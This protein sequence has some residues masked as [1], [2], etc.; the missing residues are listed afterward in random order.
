[1]PELSVLV[2]EDQPFQRLVAVSALK[3]AGVAHVYEASDGNE[4]LSVLKANGCVDI[5]ICDLRM[6]GMDGLTFLHHASQ[7]GL[8]RSVILSSDL[9]PV[10]RQAT[11]SMIQSLGLVFLGDLGK[12]FNLGRAKV[13]LQRYRRPQLTQSTHGEETAA[14][15]ASDIQRGLNNGEFEAYYQPKVSLATGQ[16]N[17]AEVLARW[18]HPRLGI[19]SPIRFLPVMEANDLVGQLF[20]ALFSQG[21]ALQKQLAERLQPIELAFNL[22]VSQLASLELL[23]HISQSLEQSKLPATG[24]MFEV[25][26][27]GLVLAP[28]SSLETLVRL[29]LLGC[30]LAMDDFGAGYSSLERLCEFPFSQIKLDASFVRKLDFQPRSRAII[31]STVTL[32]ESLGLSLVI[33]GVETQEQSR[34]LLELGCTL[35][36]GFLFARPMPRKHFISYCQDQSANYATP[37]TP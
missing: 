5:A 8:L 14:L 2:L 13:L 7:R 9:D 25:T 12:P 32:S 29:R 23:E 18:N 4:A 30:G 3:K 33:E 31:S 27:T 37:D 6:R 11:V 26:E 24:L 35:A 19:L 28:A 17:G 15:C 21:I 1:M 22:H 34:Q 36:Q 10:L 20:A 16:L